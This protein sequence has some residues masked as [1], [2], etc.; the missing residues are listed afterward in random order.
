MTDPWRTNVSNNKTQKVT[1]DLKI[2]IT[3]PSYFWRQL[4]CSGATALII[5]SDARQRGARQKKE[6]LFSVR[7]LSVPP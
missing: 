3:I 6:T 2:G 1:A 7:R 4:N 5:V